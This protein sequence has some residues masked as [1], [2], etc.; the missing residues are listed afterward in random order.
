MAR[1]SPVLRALGRYFAQAWA[2]GRKREIALVSVLLALTAALALVP[3]GFGKPSAA[4]RGPA[5]IIDTDDSGVRAYGPLLQGE[6]RATAR[7]LFGPFRGK[8]VEGTNF[9]FGKMDQDK[10]FRPGDIALA[11][12]DPDGKGSYAAVTFQD[13]FRLRAELGL[14]LAFIILLIVYG[15]WTGVRTLAAFSFTAVG[16]WKILIPAILSG[17]SPLPASLAMVALLIVVITYSVS[18]F[19]RAGTAAVF[20]A[21][22]GAGA[23]ALIGIFSAE[24]FKINGAVRPFSETLLYAGYDHIDLR[25]L[26]LAGTFLA[27]SGALIDLAIDVAVALEEVKSKNPSLGF[28]GLLAS[29]FSVGRK[30]FGTMTTT[31]LLAYSGG[32]MALLMVFMAQGVPMVTMFNLPYVSSEVFHTLVGSLG[33]VLVAPFTALSAA[34]LLSRPANTRR[35]KEPA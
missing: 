14:A 26:F 23:S 17:A 6:Q 29:G 3:S 4:S 19:N 22:L 5:R 7:V 11:V 34:F 24:A 20:G 27:C 21:F 13:H 2:G 15:G 18:G 10:L 32:F 16:I 12:I 33:L 8:V 30:V 28:A 31:L 1:S 25:G 35:R 9:L